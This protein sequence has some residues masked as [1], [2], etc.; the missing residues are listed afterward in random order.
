ML[1]VGEIPVDILK[2]SSIAI[3]SSKMGKSNVG[4]PKQPDIQNALFMAPQGEGEWTKKA[5]M[6]TARANLSTAVVDGKIYAF[7]GGGW[8]G[9]ISNVEEYDPIEGKW[10]KRPS[11]PKALLWHS[12]TFVDGKVYVIGGYDV[13]MIKSSSIYEYDPAL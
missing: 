4:E 11:I 6:P 10:E 7:G 13:N 3:L 9:T 8:V 12:T 2:T 1:K 5:D